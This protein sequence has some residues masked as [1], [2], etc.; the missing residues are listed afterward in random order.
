MRLKLDGR[1]YH[2]KAVDAAVEAFRDLAE[3]VV[4][5]RDGR[6]EVEVRPGDE[7]LDESFEAEFANYVLAEMSA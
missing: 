3:I 7:G 5:E 4:E 6:I 2:R 1:L